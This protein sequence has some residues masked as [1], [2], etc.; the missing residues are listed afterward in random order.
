M[1]SEFQRCW[2]KLIELKLII[3]YGVTIM[4]K[5]KRISCVRQAGG[6]TSCLAYQIK[7]LA[8]EL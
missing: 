3:S 5:Y 1:F 6:L 8:V 7:T 4:G 2:E